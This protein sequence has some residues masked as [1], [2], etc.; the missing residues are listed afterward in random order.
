MLTPKTEL[1]LKLAW[2]TTIWYVLKTKKNI[3]HWI[4][5]ILLLH[6]SKIFGSQEKILARKSSA[7]HH[8]ECDEFIAKITLF[9][10][11]QNK[12]NQREL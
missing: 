2:K 5:P 7:S 6:M 8:T 10:K 4:C 12:T 11:V 1:E 9:E 3:K